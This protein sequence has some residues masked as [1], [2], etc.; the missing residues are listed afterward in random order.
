MEKAQKVSTCIRIICGAYGYMA[1]LGLFAIHKIVSEF[2]E[3]NKTYSENTGK[4][5]MR[6]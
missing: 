1:K 5:S 3:I 4:E 2:A 6:T